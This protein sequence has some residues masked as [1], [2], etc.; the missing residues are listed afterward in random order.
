MKTI[1]RLGLEKEFEAW[2][3]D[4][5]DKRPLVLD[6]FKIG[7]KVLFVRGDIPNSPFLNKKGKVI[8]KTGNLLLVDL[9]GYG[10][11]NFY[12]YKFKLI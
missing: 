1:K 6:D 4:I 12:P 8:G 5:L 11:G 7:D 2:K 3:K 10:E 9:E